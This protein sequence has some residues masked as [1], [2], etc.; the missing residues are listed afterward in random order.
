MK[1][2]VTSIGEKTTEICCEQLK[3]Y[4][5]EVVLLDGQEKWFDKYKRFISMANEDCLR[6]DADVIPNQR[7]KE[8]KDA[9]EG[10]MMVQYSMYCFYKNDVRVGNPVL[11][12][13]RALDI[14]KRYIDKLDRLRPETAAWRLDEIR[15]HAFTN[16]LVVGMH[17]FFQNNEEVERERSRRR[18][19]FDFD[20]V[21]RLRQ[22]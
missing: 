14:I 20:L 12:R 19:V 1:A 8:V 13:K 17:G 21:D 9:F 11:Y 18:H 15:P 16:Y 7:I 2:Y 10:F 6:I 3:K 22:L 4:G 5:F